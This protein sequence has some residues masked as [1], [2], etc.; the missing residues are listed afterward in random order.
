MEFEDEQYH[1]NDLSQVL[2]ANDPNDY[3]AMLILALPYKV[4]YQQ[5]SQFKKFEKQIE[6]LT[7]LTSNQVQENSP[8]VLIHMDQLLVL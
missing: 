6:S 3:V 1:D 4:F 7:L 5:N 2:V 8:F